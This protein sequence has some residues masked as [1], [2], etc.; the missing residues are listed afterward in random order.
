MYDPSVWFFENSC[1]LAIS[2]PDFTAFIYVIEVL[3]ATDGVPSALLATA[4]AA[5]ASV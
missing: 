1:T 3:I 4:N 5:S 2:F